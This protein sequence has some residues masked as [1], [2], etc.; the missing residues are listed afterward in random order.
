MRGIERIGEFRSPGGVI[1]PAGVEA[2]DIDNGSSTLSYDAAGKRILTAIGAGYAPTMTGASAPAP[3]AVTDG[4]GSPS[5]RV[6]YQ[7]AWGA[8]RAPG[9]A[10]AIGFEPYYASDAGGIP[11]GAPTVSPGSGVFD[12]PIWLV[13]GGPSRRYAR[14]SIKA[15][16]GRYPV[17]WKLQG[18]QDTSGPWTD[19]DVRSGY[20]DAT[21]WSAAE[22]SFD[23]SSPDDYTHYRLWVTEGAPVVSGGGN[24]ISLYA[25]RFYEAGASFIAQSTGLANPSAPKRGGLVLRMGGAAVA[26]NST[27]I[28]KLSRGGGDFRTLNLRRIK[29]LA[30]GTTIYAAI[31][32]NLESLAS[33]SSM[34]ARVECSVAGAYLYGWNWGATAW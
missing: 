15:T 28:G 25:L 26:P 22:R 1:L 19:L 32:E 20:S 10:D 18:A 7:P 4:V 29:T 11:S 6:W 23:V 12:K 5:G 17:A 24:Y 30:D 33:G 2:A 16:P 27:L 13:H 21:N 34:I 31:D 3:Y 8:I 14:Y 9:A